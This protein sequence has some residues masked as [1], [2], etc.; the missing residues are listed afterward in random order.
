MRNSD[1]ATAKRIAHNQITLMIKPVGAMCNLRCTYCYYLPTLAQWMGTERRMD[2]ETLEHLFAGYLPNAGPRVTIAWQGGEPT[3]AGLEFFEQV[4]AIQKR[5]TR[6]GQRVDHA[7]QTN[8]TLLNDAWCRFL[9]DNQILVGLSLDGPDHF[10]DHYRLTRSRQGS[11]DQVLRG[12]NLL[13]DHQVEFNVLCVLNDRNVHQPDELLGYFANRDIHWLQFIPTIEW[14]RDTCTGEPR[15]APFSPDSEA[16]GRFLCRLFDRWFDQHRHQL[17]IRFFDD[18][19]L[20]LVHDQDSFCIL[21]RACHSQLTVEHD[22]SVFGCDHF[23]QPRWRLGQIENA[24]WI[25]ELSLDR[26]DTFAQRKQHLPEQCRSCQWR[27]FC[28][29]GCP[30]HRPDQGETPEPTILCTGYR[31]FFAHAM[32]RLQWLAGYIKRGQQPPPPSRLRPG[33]PHSPDSSADP[34]HC[35][36]YR[37][38]PPAAMRRALVARVANTNSATGK[39]ADNLHARDEWGHS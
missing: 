9:R 17:S 18:V 31:M 37:T 35:A 24:D 26:L 27:R 14:V 20:K 7:I 21:A 16:Y 28:H 1:S 25:D 8:G 23:V 36:T 3:L 34:L 2:V 10:H 29:G 39:A 12:L 38:R 5:H 6:A 22:G 4:L 15:L 19:L 30:K 32:D 33:I 11:S 13:R